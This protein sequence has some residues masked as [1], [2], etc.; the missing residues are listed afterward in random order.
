M[1]T[2]EDTTQL[3]FKRRN[4]FETKPKSRTCSNCINASYIGD[5]N[6]MFCHLGDFE[7]VSTARCNAH[8]TKP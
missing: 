4:K 8:V 5:Q 7:V 2:F 6:K 1:L 3:A